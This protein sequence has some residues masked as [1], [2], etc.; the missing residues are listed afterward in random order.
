MVSLDGSNRIVATEFIKLEITGSSNLATENYVLEQ[1]ALGGGGTSTTDLS[2]YYTLTQ[3]NTL[4]N[5]KYSITQTNT[6]LNTKYS[7]TETNTL[8]DT[9]YNTTSV[10]TLLDT[11]L[12]INNP[13]DMNGVLRIG[14]ITGTSKIILNAVSSTKDFYV[15]GDSQVLGNLTVSSLDSTGYVNVQSIQTNTF[16]AL[17]TNDILFQSNNDTY[18]QYDVS[19][20]KLIANKSIQCGGNL[21][22]QEVDTI[23]PLD[24]VFKVSGESILELKTDDRIVANK[25]I[26]CGGNIKTQEI[27]TIAPLDLI[28]KRG[29]VTEIEVKDNETQFNCDIRLN[30]FTVKSNAFDTTGD[31]LMEIKRINDP[32]ITLETDDTISIP[33]VATFSNNI[34]CNNIITCDNFDSRS[35]STISNYIMN[36][37]TG[38]IKFYVGSP[39]APDTTTNLVMTLENNL[40]TFHKPTSPEIGAGTID[41]SNYVKKTGETAQLIV[42]QVE[43]QGLTTQAYKFAMGG[44]SLFAQYRRFEI[45]NSEIISYRVMK[46]TNAL[47][48]QSNLINSYTDTD[49]VFQRNG[50]EYMKLSTGATIDIS[51]TVRLRSNI[52]MI[53]LIMLM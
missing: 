7:I 49:L 15:N 30:G 35:G 9:K 39:I 21:T 43:F 34:L 14:H 40:I 1:V 22:T 26:Q 50:I 44:P 17:N 36:D 12:N 51:D 52:Y 32:Y 19:T 18:L 10:N 4:L 33:K 2:G 8:L 25:L 3:T 42:G 11:K 6:L 53:V 5:E 41:D 48:L 47:G 23:A 20:N 38:Q 16:N 29:G 37:N 27:D 46:F 28:I 31:V 24:L 13:Q 45:Y